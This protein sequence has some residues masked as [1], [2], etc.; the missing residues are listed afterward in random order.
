MK[1]SSIPFSMILMTVSPQAQEYCSLKKRWDQF[2][3][4]GLLKL[5]KERTEEALNLASSH[6]FNTELDPLQRRITFLDDK[7]EKNQLVIPTELEQS[8]SETCCSE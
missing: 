1:N 8:S 7:I 4:Q 5:A 2:C 3:R 6:T